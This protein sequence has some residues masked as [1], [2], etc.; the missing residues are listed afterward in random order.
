MSGRANAVTKRD[1]YRD[2]V[3]DD[4]APLDLDF[5]GYLSKKGE[6]DQCFIFASYFSSLCLSFVVCGHGD[7]GLGGGKRR[8]C[9]Q[10][11]RNVILLPMATICGTT[12]L[13]KTTRQIPS[14]SL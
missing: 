8:A 1:G 13:R 4:D 6:P 9:L 7:T 12:R 11:T 10:V 14:P 3:F 5:K 2:S